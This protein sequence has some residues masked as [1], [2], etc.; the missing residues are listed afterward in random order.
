MDLTL[1]WLALVAVLGAFLHLW[2]QSGQPWKQTIITAI[3]TGAAVAVGYKLQGTT[4]QIIDF[5][6]VLIAG[7]GVNAG[8]TA[9]RQKPAVTAYKNKMNQPK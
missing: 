4:V 1:L 5:F 6:M 7:Y 3:I 2:Q 9:I 8:V